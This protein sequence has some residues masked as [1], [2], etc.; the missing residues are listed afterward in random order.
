KSAHALATKLDLIAASPQADMLGGFWNPKAG[1]AR[2][3]VRVSEQQEAS[4]KEATF[5]SARALARE[6]FGPSSFLTGLSFLLTQ[7]TRGVIATQWSTFFWS[8]GGILLM[9]TLAFRGPKLAVLALLP[10]MLSVGLVL[11]LM[12]WIGVK[13]DVATALIASVALGLS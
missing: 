8:A 6:V 5:D 2:V 9:L 3:L 1:R 13:L 10:T 7:T 12:G 11:G 4:V